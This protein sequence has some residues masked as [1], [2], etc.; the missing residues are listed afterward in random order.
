[1]LCS[2]HLRN[3]ISVT[4]TL[5]MDRQ[6][7]HWCAPHDDLDLFVSGHMTIAWAG[8]S[9]SSNLAGFFTQGTF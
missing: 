8:G 1:M 7:T 6:G 2:Q 3:V 5:Y 4:D 9:L